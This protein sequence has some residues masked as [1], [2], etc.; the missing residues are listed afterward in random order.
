MMK[1]P[2]AK[3]RQPLVNLRIMDRFL[4]KVP[5]LPP[6]HGQ[7]E[8]CKLAM[9]YFNEMLAGRYDDLVEIES[10]RI[11]FTFNPRPVSQDEVKKFLKA[12]ESN[13]SLFA[14]ALRHLNV[15]P[16]LLKGY[17]P[18][19]YS[20]AAQ[21]LTTYLIQKYEAHRG[22]PQF[23]NYAV[24]KKANQEILVLEPDV[25]GSYEA[26]TL[27]EKLQFVKGL[28]FILFG[29]HPDDYPTVQS[30]VEDLRTALYRHLEAA[31]KRA[32]PSNKPAV[33]IN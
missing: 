2:P 12:V 13:L 20:P 9:G 7:Y 16:S 25:V 1:N 4:E 15:N 10:P 17:K 26:A 27:E 14:V 11:A 30:N 5:C 21:Q 33:L 32:G 23:K 6:N 19:D 3:A 29:L 8:A 24:D 28:L 31:C 22:Q 18:S